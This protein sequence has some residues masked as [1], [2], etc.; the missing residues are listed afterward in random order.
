MWIDKYNT[1]LMDKIEVH[2]IKI[3]TENGLLIIDRGRL[4]DKFKIWWFQC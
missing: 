3:R 2:V 4:V 1:E